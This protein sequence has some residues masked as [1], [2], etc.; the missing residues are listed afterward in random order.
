[1]IRIPD[2]HEGDEVRFRFGPLKGLVGTVLRSDSAQERVVVLM[3]HLSYQAKLQ[4]DRYQVQT[5]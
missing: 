1:M 3:D 5:I 2:V 4:V